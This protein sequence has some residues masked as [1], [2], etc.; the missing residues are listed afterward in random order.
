MGLIRYN[1]NVILYFCEVYQYFMWQRGVDKIA[2]FLYNASQDRDKNSH[3]SKH[4][5]RFNSINI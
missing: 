4:L 2:E 5:I 3:L 1:N